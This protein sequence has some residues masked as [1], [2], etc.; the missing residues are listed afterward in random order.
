MDPPGLQSLPARPK[1]R[2][3]RKR[4]EHFGIAGGSQPHHTRAAVAPGLEIGERPTR[5]DGRR[6]VARE[7]EC[8]IQANDRELPAHP[9]WRLAL[10]GEEIRAALR[11]GVTQAEIQAAAGRLLS[12]AA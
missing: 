12:L 2:R 5:P 11:P 8:R 10:L 7:D 6:E 3:H 1:H 9:S 4:R